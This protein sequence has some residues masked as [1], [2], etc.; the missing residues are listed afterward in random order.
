MTDRLDIPALWAELE[1]TGARW[2][3]P[4]W[5]A[6]CH[7]FNARDIEADLGAALHRGAP[8]H[9]VAVLL[10]MVDQERT[11]AASHLIAWSEEGQRAA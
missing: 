9:T 2:P 11:L 8:P 5:R 7:E 10:R 4:V 3:H 1:R 6:A